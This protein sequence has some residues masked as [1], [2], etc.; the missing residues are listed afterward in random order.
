[1]IKEDLL[2][3]ETQI[4]ELRATLKSLADDEGFEKFIGTIY[5]A[6]WTTPGEFTLVNGVVDS[7]VQQAKTML[8]LKQALFTGAE[9]IELN[10]H[11]EPPSPRALAQELMS[12]TLP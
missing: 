4:R 3:V 7:M 1:M 2:H 6:R 11:P 8:G 5:H 10:P 9:A 12:H